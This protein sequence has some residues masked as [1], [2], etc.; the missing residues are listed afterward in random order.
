MTKVIYLEKDFLHL[1]TFALSRD[2]SKVLR[3]GGRCCGAG[4]GSPSEPKNSF[5]RQLG[6]LVANTLA[7]FP[8]VQWLPLPNTASFP[9]L[10][11]LFTND[12]PLWKL[13]PPRL[14]PE[15]PELRHG[16]FVPSRDPGA[17]G[18]GMGLPFPGAVTAPRAEMPRRS[19]WG[20]TGEQMRENELH[21]LPSLFPRGLATQQVR[22][23]Q[24][25]ILLDTL[26]V[27]FYLTQSYQHLCMH[28]YMYTH[29]KYTEHMYSCLYIHSCR[30]LGLFYFNAL[31]FV[32]LFYGSYGLNMKNGLPTKI[33]SWFHMKLTFS[34]YLH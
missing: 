29:I 20:E 32:K 13:A 9:T 14:F 11:I 6:G 30:C 23:S 12:L 21:P 15:E 18:F 27:C 25:E 5:L 10:R 22:L 1:S 19:S 16:L 34:F 7:N 3:L 2:F 28:I 31:I 24:G 8:A 26:L 4:P 33:F 17:Q